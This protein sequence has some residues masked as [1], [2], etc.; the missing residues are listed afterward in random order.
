MQ[1]VKTWQAFENR[2]GP[3]LHQLKWLN[4][5]GGH[6][7]TR[8]DYDRETLER[9]I[10]YIQETYDCRFTW[11]QEKRLPLKLVISLPAF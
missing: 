3:Y 1:I 8:D 2:F 11:N 6:H 4:M 7:I 5:D 10:T 9:L